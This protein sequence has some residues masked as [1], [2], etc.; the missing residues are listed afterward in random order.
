MMPMP[1]SPSSTPELS[2]VILGYREQDRLPGFVAT[3]KREVHELG[4]PF[5]IILI[6]NYWPQI[7][8]KT[9]QVAMQL[10][11]KD[12]RITVVSKPKKGRMGWDMRSGLKA[13]RGR[14]ITIIDGDG[15]FQPSDIAKL[16]HELNDRHLDLCQTYRVQR[17]DGWV[18][19]ILSKVYNFVFGLLFPGTG[20]SDVNAKPKLMTRALYESLQL[21]S[22]DWFIDAEI[23]IQARRRH[24]PM[25]QIPS[26]FGKKEGK[27]Y[28][29]A[30]SL[31]EFAKNLMAFR[32][33][34]T[35]R[36]FRS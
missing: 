10:A 25:G 29:N 3:V 1:P 15:Q 32:L 35:L 34:E 24:C 11:E 20:L 13:A 33:R 8:D 30:S 17:A 28:I 27:S 22:D 4:I 12:P 7:V 6:A 14:L 31:F 5:E 2:V 26:I 19:R 21:T 36:R 18:R 9:P 23:V 16:Y